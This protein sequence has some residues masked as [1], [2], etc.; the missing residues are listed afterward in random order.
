MDSIFFIPENITFSGIKALRENEDYSKQNSYSLTEITR[1]NLQS[2]IRKKNLEKKKIQNKA[3]VLF[4]LNES[5]TNKDLKNS[6]ES[7]KNS[8]G[9]YRN[10]KNSSGSIK[11]RKINSIKENESQLSINRVS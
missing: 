11:F 7:Y 8:V 6:I 4:F 9:S 3:E 1:E 2:Y 10:Q 5:V